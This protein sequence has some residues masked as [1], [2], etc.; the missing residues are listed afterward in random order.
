MRVNTYLNF[1]GNCAD[2]LK[3]YEANL[4]AKTGMISTYDQAPGMQ[5][6]PGMEKA[7]MHA[8]ITLGDTVVMASDVPPERF[9]PIRSAYLTISVDSD[10]EAERIYKVLSAG[11][12]VFMEIQETFFASRFAPLRD[13]FGVLLMIIHEKPMG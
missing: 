6:P 12:E 5:P 1:G 3:F 7:V 13:K 11:G 8:R 9:Q 2:A 10:A 4:G